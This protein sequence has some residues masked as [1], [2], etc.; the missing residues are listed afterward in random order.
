MSS[1]RSALAAK[2]A[3]EVEYPLPIGPL[4]AIDA[5]QE[6][7]TAARRTALRA[8]L[9]DGEDSEAAQQA[10]A[11]V[12]AAEQ[13]V[14][15]LHLVLVLRNLPPAEYEALIDEHPAT[16]DDLAAGEPAHRET[17]LPALIAAT[18]VD[19]EPMAVDEWDEELLSGRWSKAERDDLYERCKEINSRLRLV[20]VPKGSAPTRRSPK[21]SRT[22]SR[23]ASRTRRS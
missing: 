15:D 21:S 9:R 5:A 8:V 23:S 4:D 2:R 16:A 18:V 3:V 14:R 12:A 1:L 20:S 19:D 11:E 17:F 22:A 10:E 6:A 7:L 13:A